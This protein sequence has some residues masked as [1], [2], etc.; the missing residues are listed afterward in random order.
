MVISQKISEKIMDNRGS[1]SVAS[2]TVKEQRVDGSWCGYPHLR[3][4]LT[5]FE[6]NHVVNTLSK[7]QIK[8]KRYYTTDTTNTSSSGGPHTFVK[9][10]GINP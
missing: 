4:T 8:S 6:I 1:K 2:A 9:S 3:C 5:G 7:E 10:G